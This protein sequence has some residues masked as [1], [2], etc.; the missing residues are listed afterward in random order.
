MKIL[1]F[2]PPVQDFYDTD[3][4][5]QPI[6]LAYLKAAI[7]K[8]HPDITVEIKDFHHG[9]GRRTVKIPMAL[10]YL[11]EYYPYADFSPFSTFHN[12]YHFGAPFEKI[13]EEV[14]LSNPDI[15]GIS[16]LFSP[17]F[18]EVLN[19]A[20]LIKKKLS[21]PIILGGNHVTCRPGDMLSN[22]NIDFV[23]RGEGERAIVE[24]LSAFKEGGDFSKVPNLG[25]KRG[26]ELIFNPI[27]ENF[28]IDELPFPDLSDFD[29]KK[30]SFAGQP[31][32]FVL[33]SRG[34]PWHCSFCTVRNTFGHKYRK[35]SIENILEEI[36]RG[37][38]MGIRVFDF[39]D[40]SLGFDRAH[41]KK[42]CQRLRDEFPQ[43]DVTFLAMNGIFY[44]HLDTET[45]KLMRAAGFKQLNISLVSL[46]EQVQKNIR[47]TYTKEKYLA[48]LKMA[49]ALGFKI[50]SYQILGL[51]GEGVESI[52]NGLAFVANLPVLIGP[53]IF[54]L[55]PGS[56]IAATFAEL[57]EGDII[58]SRLTAM[59]I[60]STMISRDEIYSLFI[61]ARIL[62]F[63]K[64]LNFSGDKVCLTEALESLNEKGGRSGV[65]PE[66][67]TRLLHEKTLYA[68]TKRGFLPLKKFKFA[69]FSR[70]FSKL[71]GITTLQGKR[72]EIRKNYLQVEVNCN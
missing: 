7:N 6:G 65:V 68:A 27:I 19:C 63:F 70:L 20:E 56:P 51:P 26:G 35:R 67:M 22:A 46:D 13:V 24:F 48:V 55:T 49:Y 72:I 39:E 59:A 28:P 69:I 32:S 41:F 37:Y 58:K 14:C 15:I 18:L 17:Y 11:K 40:D 5:L 10:S 45:L 29:L 53:S 36:R 4:R 50:V 61:C 33:S 38:S 44:Q 21:V 8:Y 30:Y 43:K 31:S 71:G 52:I 62:N 64:G 1:L 66:I 47:R 25:Y 57:S 16:S 9:R 12:Y 2:Q 42:L 3:I 54:Y 34:C 60:E 23:I